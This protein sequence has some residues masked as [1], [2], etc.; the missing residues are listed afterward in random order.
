MTIP[1]KTSAG[2]NDGLSIEIDFDED[3]T[4]IARYEVLY[5]GPSSRGVIRRV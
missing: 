3:H 2:E 4:K 1:L 5:L